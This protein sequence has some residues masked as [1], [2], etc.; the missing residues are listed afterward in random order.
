[1][2]NIIKGSQE[3]LVIANGEPLPVKH[4]QAL[5]QD[6]QVIVLDGAYEGVKH[7]G[8]SIAVLLGDFD[9]IDPLMLSEA[10]HTSVVVPAPDQ[11]KTD[12]E[13]GLAYLDALT[14]SS[15]TIVGATGRR[16]QHTLENLRLLKCYHNSQR[17][18]V[19]LS[20][21]ETI[22]YHENTTITLSGTIGDAVSILGFPC[23]RV[24]TLGLT[25]DM[26]NQALQFD[27]SNSISNALASE[28]ATL[29][30]E[31][32]VLVIVEKTKPATLS[33]VAVF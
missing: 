4:L 23:A 27:L 1:M 21:S 3:W 20:E 10:R 8:L 29:V 5:A 26:Q 13:K 18:L 11:N 7:V 17:P 2:S 24:S 16:L 32:G 15:I 14:P 9:S 33:P 25:Y 31:G 30:I 22:A 6:R 19:M 12:L 28:T